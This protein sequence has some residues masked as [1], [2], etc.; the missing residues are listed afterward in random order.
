MC[1]F[2]ILSFDNVEWTMM[3]LLM[4]EQT[5]GGGELSIYEQARLRVHSRA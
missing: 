2:Q 1:H 5:I 4:Y 3:D